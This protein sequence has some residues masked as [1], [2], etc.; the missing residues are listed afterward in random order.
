MSPFVS[1]V[2]AGEAKR[3]DE[4]G[5]AGWG[6]RTEFG[7]LQQNDKDPPPMQYAGAEE[8]SQCAEKATV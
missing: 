5:G 2:L 3:G 8:D 6:P 4:R 7:V 1:I